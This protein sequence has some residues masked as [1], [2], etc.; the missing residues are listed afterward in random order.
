MITYQ[1]PKGSTYNL[2]EDMLNQPHLLIAGTTGSGKSV[3]L[4]GLMAT[5]LYRAPVDKERGAGFIL[6]DPKGTELD[7]YREL[8]HTVYY[9]SRPAEYVQALQKAADLMEQRNN[10]TAQRRRADRRVSKVY[11]GADLYIVIDEWFDLITC[12]YA[13]QIKRLVQ[14]IAAKGRSARVHI[15]LCTQVALAKV[16]PTEIRD[17]FCARVGLRTRDATA[18][19]VI[20]GMAGLESL[21]RHGKGYYMVPEKENEGLYDIPYIQG[22][23]IY[24]LID[25]WMEQDERHGARS[26]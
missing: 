22:D 23:E 7:D 8:P 1:M 15:I 5:L 10:I 26:A 16:L 9:A 19:K 11:D 12:E 13:A 21:P 20:L 3:L 24:N 2:F 18:S 6:I 14:W 4:N 17:N 25:W